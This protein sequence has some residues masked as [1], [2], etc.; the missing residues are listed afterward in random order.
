MAPLCLTHTI[1][2]TCVRDVRVSKYLEIAQRCG[3]HA[4]LVPG[5]RGR[6]EAG[7]QAAQVRP[8]D[9]LPAPL[10]DAVVDRLKQGKVRL[11]DLILSCCSTV[12]CVQFTCT[13][14][15]DAALAQTPGLEDA[16]EG[17][18]GAG[19]RGEGHLGPGRRA[20]AGLLHQGR[21]PGRPHFPGCWRGQ[22]A[23]AYLPGPGRTAGQRY[24]AR[25]RAHAGVQA[26]SQLHG[27]LKQ[28]SSAGV[29]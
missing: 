8:G 6:A 29:G 26:G 28:F 4:S 15:G 21:G 23:Q 22:A 10:L 14:L 5:C 24:G 9:P 27:S 20:G 19:D 11:C 1:S 13:Y 3:G 25:E 12:H 16:G 7:A 17:P 18:R 2:P